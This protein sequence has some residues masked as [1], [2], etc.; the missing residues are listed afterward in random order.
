MH[1]SQNLDKKVSL[2]I[3]LRQHLLLDFINIPRN[4]LACIPRAILTAQAIRLLLPM[5]EY[6][7]DGKPLH[8][9][10]QFPINW[11]ALI[12]IMS[13]YISH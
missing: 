3:F 8:Y 6:G 5:F 9:T 10:I 7:F 4:S 12:C 1:E 2:N 13:P 11:P